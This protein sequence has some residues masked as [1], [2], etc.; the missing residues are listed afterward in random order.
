MDNW[1]SI[2]DDGSSVNII[3]MDCQMASD[4]AP[5]CR[6]LAKIHAFTVRGK[7]FKWLKNF[8]TVRQQNIVI[9]GTQS[10]KVHV[11][12]GVYKGP[13]LGR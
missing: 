7:V 9:N 4:S 10:H 3:Y 2:L 5:H 12:S 6:L 13:L 11:N 8:L 1:T